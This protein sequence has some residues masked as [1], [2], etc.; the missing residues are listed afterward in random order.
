MNAH[1]GKKL[2]P[3]AVHGSGDLGVLNGA[4]YRPFMMRDERVF[5]A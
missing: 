2:L 3:M 1:S 4:D 5:E